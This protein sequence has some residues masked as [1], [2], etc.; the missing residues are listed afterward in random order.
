M[1]NFKNC[2]QIGEVGERIAI[3][4]LAKYGIDV[5]LPMSDNLPFD[6]A[7]FYNNKIYKCQVKSTNTRTASG[8]LEFSLTSNN[9]NKGTKY[10]YSKEDYDILILCDLT[11]IYLLRFEEVEGKSVFTIRDSPPKSN[12]V[13]G[14]HLASDYIISEER[15]EKVLG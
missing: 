13:K 11:N 12:Q 7:I 10:S 15:L 5:L 8:G 1:N 4:E 9:W 2:K 6:F 14:I 3:G